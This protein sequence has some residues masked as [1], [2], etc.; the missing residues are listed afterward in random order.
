M[1]RC[2]RLKFKKCPKVTPSQEEEKKHKE[3]EV[4]Y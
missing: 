2:L 4:L 1:L 3:M